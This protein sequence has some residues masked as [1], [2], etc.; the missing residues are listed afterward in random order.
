MNGVT[1]NELYRFNT[2]TFDRFQ[3]LSDHIQHVASPSPSSSFC[4]HFLVLVLVVLLV[5]FVL[6]CLSVFSLVFLFFFSCS[7]YSVY[8]FS[9]VPPYFCSRSFCSFSS[10]SFHLATSSHVAAAGTV[11]VQH[12]AV[13]EERA[14]K[15]KANGHRLLRRGLVELND[16]SLDHPFTDA[17][18]SRTVHRRT[19]LFRTA[20]SPST[21]NSHS[22]RNELRISY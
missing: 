10:F 1:V 17:I 2:S 12:V 18:H 8:F 11:D 15:V 7:C 22:T 20:A 5:L 16:S 9:I 4:S 6:S 3:L 14:G 21:H 19:G 13:S